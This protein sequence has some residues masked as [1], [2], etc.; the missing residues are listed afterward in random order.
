MTDRSGDRPLPGRSH[1]RDRDLEE[2]RGA[3][4]QN[5]LHSELTE[6][7]LQRCL[8][9]ALGRLASV[10]VV[11]ESLW[12]PHNVSAV[13]RTAE[14]L[15]LDQVHVVEEPHGYRRHP[16]ILQGADRWLEIVRHE[17]LASGLAALRQR[18]FLTCAADV[19]PGCLTLDELPSEQPVAIV[20]GSEKDGLTHQAKTEADLRFT[21]P[22]SGFTGSLNV[23]VSA[24]IALY[25]LTTKRR[26]HLGSDGDLDVA[27]MTQRVFDWLRETRQRKTP[28]R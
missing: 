10:T 4:E 5:P 27:A 26:K 6:Q 7:R 13:V 22:M 14:G 21:I 8:H 9:V 24:A 18:G 3:V 11:L 28:S 25:S 19:G 23:S 2:L 17:T 16:S 15:G 20:L 12:D 1:L